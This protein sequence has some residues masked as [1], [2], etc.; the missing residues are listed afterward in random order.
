MKGGD[1]LFKLELDDKEITLLKMSIHHCLETCKDGGSRN[2]CSDCAALEEVLK[3][4]P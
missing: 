2:G 4:L 3:K 1:Y